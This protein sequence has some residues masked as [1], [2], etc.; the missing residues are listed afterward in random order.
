MISGSYK[1]RDVTAILVSYG[2]LWATRELEIEKGESNKLYMIR[3]TEQ[4]ANSEEE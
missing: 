4:H 3:I 2:Y 1:E